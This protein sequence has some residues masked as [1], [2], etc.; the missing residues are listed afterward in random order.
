MGLGGGEEET[1][2]S[3]VIGAVVS[4]SR[5]SVGELAFGMSVD[6]GGTIAVKVGVEVESGDIG[7]KG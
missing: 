7:L 1:I 4:S 6:S 5:I 3:F 2:F